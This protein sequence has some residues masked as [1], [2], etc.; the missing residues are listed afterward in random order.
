MARYLVV[1]NQTLGGAA[2]AELVRSRAAPLVGSAEFHIVVPA[3]APADQD[4]PGEGDAT[5]IAERRLRAA[6]D[7]LSSVAGEAPVTG[8]VGSEDPMQAISDALAGNEY[9]EIIISTL[10]AGVSKWL[11]TDLPRKVERKFGLPVSS[12]ESTEAP[13]TKSEQTPR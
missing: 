11:R 10:P 6:L 4:V 13:P 2:L 5:A 9:R 3:T 1:A 8:N 12:I 7:R